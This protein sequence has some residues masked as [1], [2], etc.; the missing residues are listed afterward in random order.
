MN[1]IR[2]KQQ[3]K[4]RKA[5]ILEKINRLSLD[6]NYE[7]LKPAEIQ[8]LKIDMQKPQIPLDPSNPSKPP[9]RHKHSVSVIYS[10]T[11]FPLPI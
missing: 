4:K 1:K 3:L 9:L 6:F 8:D 10:S 2:L 7:T 5:Q 11:S